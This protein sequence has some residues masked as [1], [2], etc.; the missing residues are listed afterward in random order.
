M[1]YLVSEFRM[2]S[3]SFLEDLFPLF[4]ASG[5]VVCVQ[6]IRVSLHSLRFCVPR[7]ESEVL[8]SLCSVCESSKIFEGMYLNFRVQYIWDFVFRV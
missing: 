3:L 7:F 8:E 6:G 1:N 5:I 4:L 2:Q